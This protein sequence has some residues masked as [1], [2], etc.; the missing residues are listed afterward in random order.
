VNSSPEQC[1]FRFVWPRR[2]FSAIPTTVV[3]RTASRVVLWIATDTPVGRPPGARLPIAEL[4]EQ[5]WAFEEARWYGGRLMISEVGASHSVYVTW[6]K[7]G[8]LVGWYV[9]LEEPWRESSFGF[10][11]TDHLLD[12]WIDPDRVLALEGRGR[13]RRGRRDRALHPCQGRCNQGRGR[14]SDRAN[15]S[16]VDS[17]RR[18]LGNLAPG[19]RLAAPRAPRRLG[20]PLTGSDPRRRRAANPLEPP[21]A[22]ERLGV[23]RSTV[24]TLLEQGLTPGHG[25]RERGSLRGRFA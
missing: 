14:A 8:E 20:R 23:S 12:V 25:L 3:E 17:V 11:T 2:V 6:G 4:A 7:D 13:A 16:V 22:V 19:S 21:R 1:L 18:R 5:R 10:D 24:T 9:N 15:R